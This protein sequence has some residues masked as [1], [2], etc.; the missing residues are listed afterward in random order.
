VGELNCGANDKPEEA[1]HQGALQVG[2]P[3]R[4]AAQK[5]VEPARDGVI[6]TLPYPPQRLGAS[7]LSNRRIVQPFRDSVS[8]KEILVQVGLEAEQLPPLARIGGYL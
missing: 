3:E 2:T 4:V 1:G 8:A 7:A 5:S 6:R